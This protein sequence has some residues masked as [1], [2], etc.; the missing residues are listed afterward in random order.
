MIDSIKQLIETQFRLEFFNDTTSPN[1]YKDWKKFECDKFE[2]FSLNGFYI[3]EKFNRQI[4]MKLKKEFPTLV[5]KSE[6]LVGW[7]IVL[8][9]FID[10]KP[11]LTMAGMEDDDYLR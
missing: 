3:I 1:I 9:N 2:E 6:K 5:Y 8:E 4:E 11:I 7:A 10:P